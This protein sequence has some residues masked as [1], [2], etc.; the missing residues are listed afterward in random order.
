MGKLKKNPKE[1]RLLIKDETSDEV[2]LNEYLH[3]K[4]ACPY[5]YR[6][7]VMLAL[8]AFWL[9][10]AYQRLGASSEQ[11]RKVTIDAIYQLQRHLNYLYSQI[12]FELEGVG[13]M[14]EH[15]V[16]PQKS[17]NSNTP[18]VADRGTRPDNES[19]PLE[20]EQDGQAEP[21]QWHVPFEYTSK[22][23]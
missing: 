13:V 23:E 22:F 20:I 12:G 14:L 21:D 10:F 5:S 3:D 1:I 6:E 18:V 8:K 4:Q 17:L 9:P 16:P 19:S 11:L 15:S 2:V 7:M